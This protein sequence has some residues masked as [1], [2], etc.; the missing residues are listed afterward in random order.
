LRHNASPYQRTRLLPHGGALV[1]ALLLAGCNSFGAGGPRTQ[2]VMGTNKGAV[3]NSPIQVVEVTDAVARRLMAA[4][5]PLMLS[6]ALGDA[7]PVGT[8]VGRG[9]VLDI[10]IWEAPPAALF[11]VSSSMSSGISAT[12]ATA[13]TGRSATMPEQM[14]DETGRINVPFAGQIPA[15]GRSLQQIGTEIVARLQGLAHQPQVMV[16]TTRNATA[17]VTIVGEVSNSTRITLTPRG[18][19]LLDAL[20]AAGGVRQPVNKMTLQVT[21][22]SKTAALPLETIIK[23]PAQNIRLA[24]DDVVT[25]LYQPYSFTALGASGTNAEVN[26]EGTGLTLSQALGRIG[27]LRDE[28]ANPKG[29]FVF[30]L[31][32]PANLGSGTPIGRTTPDGKVPVVYR[33]DMANPAS[34]FV[35]QGFPIRNRDVVYISNAPL[36]DFQ[37]FVG[38][39]SQLAITGLS[40]GNAVP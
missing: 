34:L 3:A 9:D 19:R 6:E 11:S 38:L 10:T 4:N 26:F 27:G 8:L 21:R 31:E 16:R 13:A 30:R 2:A 7:R 5:R 40:I 17:N 33:V 29:V 37:K 36:V 22:G 23:E 39:V 1:A 14:V 18:E 20:A 24:A 32:D 35:A 15:A 28:R 25:A 12:T